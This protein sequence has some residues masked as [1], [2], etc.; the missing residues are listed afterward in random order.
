MTTNGSFTLNF[1]QTIAKKV[2]FLVREFVW[3]RINLKTPEV[4]GSQMS[5]NASIYQNLFLTFFYV[6]SSW[7]KTVS[8]KKPLMDASQYLMATVDKTQQNSARRGLDKCLNPIQELQ[9][10]QWNLQNKVSLQHLPYL[11][12]LC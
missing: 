12:W 11:V 1:L 10:M 4:F 2:Y 6:Y 7:L 5:A 3:T 9:Q 8:Y